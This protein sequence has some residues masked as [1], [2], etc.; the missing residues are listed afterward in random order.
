MRI[1]SLVVTSV[2]AAVVLCF[3]GVASVKAV[4]TQELMD[5]IAQLQAQLTQLQSQQ[6]TTA[7]AE[8]YTF[9]KTLRMG[10]YGVEVQKLVWALKKNGV[11]G[12]SAIVNNNSRFDI[13]VYRAVIAFQRKYAISQIGQVGPQTRIKLNELYGC[14]STS[15]SITSLGT[16][17][18]LPGEKVAFMQI[19]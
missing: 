10:D 3:G 1:K 8:C 5:Q 12:A 13:A 2:L 4:S 9:T 11:Q 17:N 18:A 19:I 14:V 16:N 6:N 15:P 7:P